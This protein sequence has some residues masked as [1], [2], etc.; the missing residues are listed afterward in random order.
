MRCAEADHFEAFLGASVDVADIL[1]G[2]AE[3][4]AHVLECILTGQQVELLEDETKR[5][6]PQISQIVA[7]HLG[8]GAAVDPHLARCG[9]VERPDQVHQRRLARAGRA[10]DRNEFALDECRGLRR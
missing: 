2:V 6:V 8:K 3:G 1:A 5:F 9:A 4:Q 7:R 10:H